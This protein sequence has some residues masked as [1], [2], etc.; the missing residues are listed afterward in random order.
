ME[1]WLRLRTPLLA[2][3]IALP[4]PLPA[5]LPVMELSTMDRVPALLTPPPPPATFPFWRVK[6]CM[7]AVTPLWTVTPRR[8]PCPSVVDVPACAEKSA[9]HPPEIVTSLSINTT[10][11]PVPVY[12]PSAT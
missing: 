6:R 4:E 7:M 10:S 9:F 2:L 3:Y 11:E 8:A 5:T 1:L 12:V